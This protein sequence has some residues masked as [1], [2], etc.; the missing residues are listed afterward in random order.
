MKLMISLKLF[1]KISFIPS[2]R[3]TQ[4]NSSSYEM[5]NAMHVGFCMKFIRLKVL[6]FY[7][8]YTVWEYLPFKMFN[9]IFKGN[10]S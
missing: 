10:S 7:F 9:K 5:P 3:E 6:F 8:N 2:E 1:P 4:Y